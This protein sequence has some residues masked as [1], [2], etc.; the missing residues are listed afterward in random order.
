MELKHLH[1]QQEDMLIEN[2][3]LFDHYPTKLDT[4]KTYQIQKL[5]RTIAPIVHQSKHKAKKLGKQ[6][7]KIT[8]YYRI[9]KQRA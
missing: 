8:T 4:M 9:K 1:A 6:Q 5:I 7:C 3:A 2:R